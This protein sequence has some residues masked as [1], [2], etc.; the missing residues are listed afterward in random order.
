MKIFDLVKSGFGKIK[1]AWLDYVIKFLFE[2]MKEVPLVG[3]A[4]E[5][6]NGHKTQLGR[7]GLFLTALVALLQTHYP[8]IPY[9]GDVQTYLM[10]AV[11]YV[12]TELGLQHKEVK[13][14]L[15]VEDQTSATPE[16]EKE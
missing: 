10:A 6:V 14:K 15:E 8:E 11:A 2:N 16:E 12:F 3:K 13:A 7:G 5:F 4:L 1:G 9:I